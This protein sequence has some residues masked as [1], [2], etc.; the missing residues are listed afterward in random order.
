MISDIIIII[1]MFQFFI[2]MT[3]LVHSLKDEGAGGRH[4]GLSKDKYIW[5]FCR[6]HGAMVW[7]GEVRFFMRKGSMRPVVK[8]RKDLPKLKENFMKL[9][10]HLCLKYELNCKTE[11]RRRR[12]LRRTSYD[13]RHVFNKIWSGS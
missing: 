12:P 2:P 3:S 10:R 9:K 11:H 8:L 13:S 6:H 5:Q 7:G 4:P 1:L